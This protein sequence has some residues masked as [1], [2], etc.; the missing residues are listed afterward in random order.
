MEKMLYCL[1]EIRGYPSCYLFACADDKEQYIHLLVRYKNRLPAELYAYLVLDN[2]ALILIGA[3]EERTISEYMRRVSLSYSRYFRK[4]YAMSAKTLFKK[5]YQ[6]TF[7]SEKDLPRTVKYLHDSPRR[8]RLVKPEQTYPYSSEG[9][10]EKLQP[11]IDAMKI[12]RMMKYA[13]P[14]KM[15]HPKMP[16]RDL[17]RVSEEAPLLKAGDS[18]RNSNNKA[19]DEAVKNQIR[20]VMNRCASKKD[21]AK[22][23]YRI[24]VRY[25]LS[26]RE[27]AKL[28]GVSRSTLSRWFRKLKEC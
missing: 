12:R 28:S 10:Y 4:R 7:F 19:R 16:S 22:D 9:E 21:M 8:M 26:L 6:K 14:R 23:L 17:Y 1:L 20:A 2:R 3:A 5:R 11:L 15:M 18:G 24:G 13:Q 25:D 27:L